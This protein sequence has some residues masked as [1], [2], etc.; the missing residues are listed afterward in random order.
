MVTKEEFTQMWSNVEAPLR[1]I[2]L[3]FSGYG[4]YILADGFVIESQYARLYRN[5]TVIAKVRFKS[6]R[7]V[8]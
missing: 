5:G 4:E 7:K 1:E 2:K 8:D 3:K 6:I